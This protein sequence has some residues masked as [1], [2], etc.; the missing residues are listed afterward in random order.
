M[1]RGRYFKWLRELVNCDD[2]K[3]GD[4]I[5][6]LFNKEFYWTNSMDE[7]RAEDGKA[8]R[9][10]Y[11]ERHPHASIEDFRGNPCTVLEM[12]I[13]LA[14]RWQ[15]DLVSD[16]GS[17]EGFDLYFW[18]M[19]KN[20]GLDTCTNENFDESIVAEKVTFMLDR[21]YSESGV[22]GLFPLEKEGRPTNNQKKSELW[23]QLQAYLMQKGR[24]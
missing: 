5:V 23:Y 15:V 8:L 9:D 20:L 14:R 21:A 4:L 1:S 10:L 24:F 12:M 13:A 6:Y 16:D 3:Y 19:I 7:N 18:E 22:G 11:S 2:N 17:E